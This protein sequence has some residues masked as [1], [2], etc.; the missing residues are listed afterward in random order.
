MKVRVYASDLLYSLIVLLR[1]ITDAH[2]L[3]S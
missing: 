1:M 2:T 3:V